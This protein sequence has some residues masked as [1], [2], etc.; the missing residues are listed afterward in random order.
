MHDTK[1]ERDEYVKRVYPTEGTE[2]IVKRYGVPRTTAHGWAK[3][4]G[5]KMTSEAKGKMWTAQRQKPFDQRNVNPLVF[6]SV[7]TPE[8]AYLLGF[9]WADGYIG[10]GGRIST[11]IST[12]DFKDIEWVFDKTGKWCKY[13]YPVRPCSKLPHSVAN[14]TN[15][16][17]VEFLT[18]HD[19]RVKS[20][21]SSDKILAHIPEHLRHYWWRG[22]FDGDGCLYLRGDLRQLSIGSCH[23]QDW[24]FFEDLCGR[25]GCR[26]SLIRRNSKRG[27][28]SSCVRMTGYHACKAF[29][30][31][32]YQGRETDRIGLQR[33]HDKYQELLGH[34]C[35]KR[36]EHAGVYFDAQRGKWKARIYS[37]EANG[38][39]TPLH[40]GFYTTEEEALEAR[41]LRMAQL[42][43]EDR[44][45]YGNRHYRAL[46]THRPPNAKGTTLPN[47]V[48]PV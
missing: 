13:H 25:L 4:L 38:L 28:R 46:V 11:T 6:M 12:P 21:A 39:K 36:T 22:Y 34:P 35:K 43:L 17:L 9:I 19:Y 8:S 1:Q 15:R 18:E 20:G 14:T 40:V 3:R 45:M 29:C 31:Y 48:L 10:S 44:V 24:S 42:G 32:I 27:Y 37:N 7:S 47:D 33:K 26:Y 41:R 23:D 16:P 2:P 5:L 30:D